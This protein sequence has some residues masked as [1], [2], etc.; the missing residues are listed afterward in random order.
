MMTEMVELREGAQEPPA[1]DPR[2]GLSIV[3]PLYNRATLV[4]RTIHSLLAQTN[5]D[6]EVIVVDDGSTDGSCAAVEVFS[7]PRLRLVRHERNRGVCPARNTG[8][9]LAAA[10]W[11]VMLDSDDELLPHAVATIVQMIRRC[12]DDISCLYFRCLMDDGEIAPGA[13]PAQPRLSYERY[14]S[15]L[16]ACT[17]KSRDMLHCVRKRTFQSIRFPDSV[18]LED[19][20]HLDFNWVHTSL[21]CEDIIRLYHQDAEDSL[22]KRTVR[23]DRQ[24]DARFALERAV[25]VARAIAKHGPAM[26]VYAPDLL[27]EYQ[28][29]LLTLWLLCGRRRQAFGVFLSR[30]R[31]R[32]KVAKL[33]VVFAIGLL[34]ARL[35]A[36]VR[37]RAQTRARLGRV[38]EAAAG[39]QA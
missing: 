34:D 14:L 9:D 31:A 26:R 35:L 38:A 28:S 10:D 7:D 6:F 20:Y 8:A 39:G 18:A 5:R 16:N 13:I 25:V 11:I 19:E 36:A 37:A 21:F 24:R 3:I 1:L 17:G 2:P 27:E 32:S 30:L 23:F 4:G 15:L 12:G 22:V 29:R 33:A